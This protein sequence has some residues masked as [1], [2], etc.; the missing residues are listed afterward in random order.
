ML[1]SFLDQAD[2]YRVAG[3]A[4]D[5]DQPEAPLSLLLLVDG[6]LHTRL[7]ANR[8]RK[9]LQAAG[10]GNGRYGFQWDF[11]HPLPAGNRHVI[12]IRREAD[13]TP[14][15]GSPVIVEPLPG[16]Q[17]AD[18]DVFVRTLAGLSSAEVECVVDRLV[19]QVEGVLQHLADR[20]SRRSRRRHYQW[21]RERWRREPATPATGEPGKLTAT[22]R[23]LI[24]DDRLPDP[25]RDAGSTAILSHAC[26][27]QRLG[28]E[29][30]FL[31]A[32]DFAAVDPRQAVLQS[33]GIRCCAGPYY[34]SVEEVLSRQAGE[35]DVVYLHRVANAA[36]YGE[37]ARQYFPQARQVYAVADLHHLRVAREAAVENRPELIGRAQR[38]RLLEYTAA[39]LADTVITH[40]SAEA[41]QLAAHVNATPIHTIRWSARPRPTQIPF[42]RRHGIAFVGG[43]GHPPNLDAARWLIAEIMPL[44]R[45]RD[46]HLECLLVGD[47]LPEAL[48][49]RS[50]NGIVVMGKIENLAAIFDRVRLTVAPLAYGAGI[51]GKVIDSLAAGVPCVCTRIAAEGLDLPAALAGCI[52]TRPEELA[53][54]VH[55]LHS[56]EAANLQARQAGLAYIEAEMSEDILDAQM[57]RA[58][59]L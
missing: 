6:R 52:A 48:R 32:L 41:K 23:A 21:L 39:A 1:R 17:I 26:S 47:G 18:R 56:D 31:A 29:V 4:Q 49:R 10:I 15:E 11:P 8:Y 14:I 7:L 42:E 25:E 51:K 13:A 58:L 50:G 24:I 28:F 53:A 27:L 37:L 30:T 34:A 5:D 33:L 9:D 22:P 38:L 2:H 54:A 55:R 20:D 12:D 3:W 35:F 59:L 46:P 44:L 16:P 43:Y 36:K 45:Q 19:D 40:S 57:R